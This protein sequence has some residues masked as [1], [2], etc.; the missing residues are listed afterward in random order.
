MKLISG[1]GKFVVWSQ[2]N[3]RDWTQNDKFSA[4]G[5]GTQVYVKSATNHD[6]H[7]RNMTNNR[8]DDMVGTST[9]SWQGNFQQPGTYYLIVENTGS[10]AMNYTLNITGNAVTFPSQMTIPVQ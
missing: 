2:D 4:V 1:Q 10:T 6:A 5:Q 9:Y 3:L 7:D 8:R